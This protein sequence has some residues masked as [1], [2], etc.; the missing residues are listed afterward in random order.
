M[1]KEDICS[2]SSPIASLG[3]LH[4]SHVRRWLDGSYSLFTTHPEF[5]VTFVKERF[6]RKIFGASPT[7]Y[8]SGVVFIDEIKDYCHFIIKACIEIGGFKPDLMITEASSAHTDFYWFGTSTKQKNVYS[9]YLNNFDYIRNFLKYFNY[10]AKT[11]M[12]D[13]YDNK[14]INDEFGDDLSP[15]VRDDFCSNYGVID[16]SS[17]STPYKYVFEY[18]IAYEFTV[19]EFNCAMCL[20]HGM[21]SKEIALK[22]GVSYRTVEKHIQKLKEKMKSRSVL[23]LISQL[24]SGIL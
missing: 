24:L 22:I 10:T 15:L 6:Y 13:V 7:E 4:F 11:F 21:S 5:S 1:I 9:F 20:C 14:L 8:K 19:Q 3:I 2:L 17:A 16:E 12:L 18:A 23:H